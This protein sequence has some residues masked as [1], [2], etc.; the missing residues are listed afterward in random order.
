M[1][2]FFVPSLA[3]RGCKDREK[4]ETP[5]NIYNFSP[6]EGERGDSNPRPLEPQSIPYNYVIIYICA[7]YSV[8]K[9]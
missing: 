7:L 1:N 3:E 2:F 4:I 5:K 6:F 9:T 8:Y